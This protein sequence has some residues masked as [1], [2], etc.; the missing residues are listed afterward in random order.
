MMLADAGMCVLV[1]IFFICFRTIVAPMLNATA[2][3]HYTNF[4]GDMDENVSISRKLY[5]TL[6]NID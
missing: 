4:W 1:I 3:E 6:V 2:S 5:L